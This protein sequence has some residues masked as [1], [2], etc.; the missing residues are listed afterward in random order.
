MNATAAQSKMALVESYCG[1]FMHQVCL[2]ISH[3]FHTA[4]ADQF[5]INLNSILALFQSSTNSMEIS[6][7]S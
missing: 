5:V 2:I 6:N 1:H 7:W 4:K 3:S